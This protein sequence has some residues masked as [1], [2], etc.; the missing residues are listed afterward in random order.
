MNRVRVPWANGGA[1]FV[2]KDPSLGDQIDALELQA[3]LMQEAADKGIRDREAKELWEEAVDARV[4]RFLLARRFERSL[5]GF[6]APR[7]DEE[8][9]DTQ[10]LVEFYKHL[11]AGADEGVPFAAARGTRL[12]RVRA[13]FRFARKRTSS[14]G[15]PS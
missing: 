7:L 6:P 8:L 2:L 5:P 12:P 4:R 13:W 14:G 11:A 9:G 15:E 3:L 1:P 10:R